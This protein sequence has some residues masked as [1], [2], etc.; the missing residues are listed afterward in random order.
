MI[1]IS[2]DNCQVRVAHAQALRK[3]ELTGLRALALTTHPPPHFS[4][5]PPTNPQLTP[6]TSTSRP[7]PFPIFRRIHTRSSSL[8][9]LLL[10][11]PWNRNARSRSR[12]YLRAGKLPFP[13]CPSPPFLI[14]PRVSLPLFAATCSF[15]SPQLWT[16]ARIL[17]SP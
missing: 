13:P 10:Q 9:R 3:V 5:P 14:W 4:P 15:P 8:N 2:I 1:I 11:T 12:H 17:K 7:S 16:R 6:N